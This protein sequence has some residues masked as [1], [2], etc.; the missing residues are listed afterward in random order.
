MKNLSSAGLLALAGICLVGIGV[1]TALGKPVPEI[2]SWA[3]A[4]ALCGLLGLTPPGTVAGVL[5][6][7]AEHEAQEP[8]RESEQ[9]KSPTEAAAL[10]VIETVMPDQIEELLPSLAPNIAAEVRRVLKRGIKL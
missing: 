4:G 3:A 10:K 2:Y 1:F 9:K 5:G 6:K 7:V 8:G